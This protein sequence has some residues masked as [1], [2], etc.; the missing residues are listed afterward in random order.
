M[1]LSREYESDKGSVVLEATGFAVLA[2]G[3]VLAL[4]I[5]LFDMERRVI[6]LEALARNAMRHALLSS[7]FDFET[8]VA[9]FKDLDPLLQGEAVLVSSTCSL[10]TCSRSGDL[11]WLELSLDGTKAKVFG[12]IP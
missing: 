1:N 12:V 2:F 3:L 8:S 11:V 4:T 6:G 5:Q 10:R 9:S 7:D